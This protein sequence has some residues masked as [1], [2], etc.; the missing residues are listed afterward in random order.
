[1]KRPVLLVVAVGVVAVV[2]LLLTML[3]GASSV[4]VSRSGVTVRIDQATTGTVVARVTAP[5]DVA[6]VSLFA[7]MPQMGHMTGEIT[8]VREGPGRFRAEGELFTMPGRWEL[9]VRA[10]GVVSFE[11]TVK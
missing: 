10:G 11:I 8:A 3:P 9:T 7:T 6:A 4:D 2:T 5:P 1:M